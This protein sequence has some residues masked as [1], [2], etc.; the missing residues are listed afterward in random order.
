LGANFAVHYALDSRRW[1]SG[2]KWPPRPIIVDQA[3]HLVTLAMMV[4]LLEL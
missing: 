4:R 3:L 2:E 1:C